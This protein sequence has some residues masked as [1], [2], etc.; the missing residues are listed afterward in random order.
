LRRVGRKV[1]IAGRLSS[2]ASGKVT[3]RYRVRHL[4]HTHTLTKRVTIARH[5][6]RSTLALSPTYAKAR[7]ATVS[8]A[9]AGDADTTPQTRTRTLR[10]TR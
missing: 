2:S 7:S 3:I 6:F 5:A 9:Y 8:V 10:P 1:T 4:G